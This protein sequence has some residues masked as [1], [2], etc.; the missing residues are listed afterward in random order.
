MSK[1]EQESKRTREQ[2]SK[3]IRE[4]IFSALLVFLS[5][6]FLVP[7]FCA[8]KE[9]AAE[10]KAKTAYATEAKSKKEKIA[11]YTAK[12]D[13][14][15]MRGEYSYAIASYNEAKKLK[16]K[17][18]KVLLRLGEAYRLADMK[19][20]AIKSYNM[21]LKYGAKDIRIFLG[22]ASVYKSKF[23]YEKS[24]E[25]YRKT[26]AVSEDNL[27]AMKGL[28]EILECKSDYRGAFELY[29][30]VFSIESTDKIKLQMFFLSI[31]FPE[32]EGIEK[33]MN[34]LPESK[35]LTG[36]LNIR[37]NPQIAISELS[38][39]DECFLK[40][41]AYLKMNDKVNARKNLEILINQKADTLSKRLAAALNKSIK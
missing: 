15:L 21:A 5:T 41:V 29:E 34:A 18:S 16:K 2:E 1:R 17:N 7:C 4:F 9:K 20:E 36:Y 13:E 25:Y 3:R 10:E 23:L 30:K 31:L 19:E 6:Y 11:F 12:G 8:D 33:Y 37:K 24:E 40:A 39:V 27:A 26:L 32:S 38:S 22:L 28:A 14:H 35:I